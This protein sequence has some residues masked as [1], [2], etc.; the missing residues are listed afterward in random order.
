MAVGMLWSI[1][2]SVFHPE[3]KLLHLYDHTIQK[4]PLLLSFHYAMD[5]YLG[6]QAHAEATIGS[7]EVCLEIIGVVACLTNLLLV[8][9]VS[10]HVSLYVPTS[11]SDQMGSFE[12][13]VKYQGRHQFASRSLFALTV[14]GMDYFCCRVCELYHINEYG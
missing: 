13:K 14:V 1:K 10:E 12:G 4:P 5:I 6:K 11:W 7:W 8:L 3:Q 9:L 2:H